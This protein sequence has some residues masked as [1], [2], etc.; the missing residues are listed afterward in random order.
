MLGS[1]FFG[2]GTLLAQKVSRPP[3]R[4]RGNGGVAPGAVVRMCRL[5][6][7]AGRSGKPRRDPLQARPPGRVHDP[8]SLVFFVR[9]PV[10]GWVFVAGAGCVIHHV[11]VEP[12]GAR[13]RGW[14]DTVLWGSVALGG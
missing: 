14:E 2:S 11:G 10:G 8:L 13:V 1:C 5:G 6:D 4:V 9:A 12:L 7:S 3:G